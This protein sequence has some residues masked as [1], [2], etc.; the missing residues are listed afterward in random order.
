MG[1]NSVRDLFLAEQP[2]PLLIDLSLYFFDQGLIG[3]RFQV[4]EA[5]L[6]HQPIGDREVGFGLVIDFIMPLFN[7]V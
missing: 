3:R 7:F 6:G 1:M 5:S 4:F 2:V